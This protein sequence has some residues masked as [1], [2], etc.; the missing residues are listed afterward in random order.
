MVMVKTW[1]E[2][3]QP[4]FP[5]RGLSGCFPLGAAVASCAA[6]SWGPSLADSAPFG[7]VTASTLMVKTWQY[8]RDGQNLARVLS[9]SYI[10]AL[11]PYYRDGQNLAR[12]PRWSKPG[13]IIVMVKTWR[14]YFQPRMVK[15]WPS[16]F[17]HYNSNHPCPITFQP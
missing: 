14:E 10:I 15:T 8:H 2:Y 16:T 13:N 3:F 7:V 12:I 6:V 11:L 17:Q 9:T 4:R 1:P 5:I